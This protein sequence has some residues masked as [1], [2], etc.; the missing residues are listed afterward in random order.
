VEEDRTHP[1]KYHPDGRKMESEGKVVLP[2]SKKNL[3]YFRKIITS[4]TYI[5]T[6][7][8]CRSI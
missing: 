8:F 1:T 2:S 6:I 7:K 4:V 3:Y 5:I